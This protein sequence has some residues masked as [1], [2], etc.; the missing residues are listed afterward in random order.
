M[1]NFYSDHLIHG[2]PKLH[3]LSIFFSSIIIHGYCPPEMMYGEMVPVPKV[4]GSSNSDDFRAITLGS[5][6]A[7]LL[8]IIL[9]NFCQETLQT[10]NLQFGFKNVVLQH[11]V[12]LFCK[13]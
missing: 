6:I 10:Y 2:S 12:H 1:N 11:V 3:K 4:T 5:I 7:K 13:M 9:L 8:D